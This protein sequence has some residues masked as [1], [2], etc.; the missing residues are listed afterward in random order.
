VSLSRNGAR[1]AGRQLVAETVQHE[2]LSDA[3]LSADEDEPAAP[4]GSYL[5]QPR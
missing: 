1:Y 5:T 2:R 4:L 3:C